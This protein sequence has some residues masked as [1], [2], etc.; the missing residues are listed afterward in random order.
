MDCWLQVL[1][2]YFSCQVG[3]N[4]SLQIISRDVPRNNNLKILDNLGLKRLITS[5][6]E[7]RFLVVDD[8]ISLRRNASSVGSHIAKTSNGNV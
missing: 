2:T 5:D 7:K 3:K 1:F 6:V 4:A 8:I